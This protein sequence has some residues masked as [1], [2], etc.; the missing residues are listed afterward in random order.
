MRSCDRPSVF[1][2]PLPLPLAAALGVLVLFTA[3]CQGEPPGGS[4]GV[5]GAGG[6]GGAP[7]CVTDADC[8]G[9]DGDCSA[10]RCFDGVC[11]IDN[12][13]IG[14]PCDEGGGKV[15]DGAGTCVGCVKGNHCPS[16]LCV[17]QKCAPATCTDGVKNGQETG[18]DCG[19][20]GGPPNQCKDGE[21]CKL[22]ADCMSAVCYK[23]V[24]QIPT[25]FDATKNGAE[26]GADC[27]GECPPC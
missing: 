21:G 8:P 25:C 1:P 2:F 19:Y 13:P 7:E 18:V 20:P 10:R 6:A 23:G 24:C 26:T 16:S 15:C 4:G 17:S 14:A 11:G 22:A 3:A 27:G 5:G 9:E 12:E